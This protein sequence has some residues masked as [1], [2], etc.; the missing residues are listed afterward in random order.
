MGVKNSPMPRRQARMDRG[1]G[2]AR[3]SPLLP[4]GKPY[5]S[6]ELAR[7]AAALRGEGAAATECLNKRDCGKWHVRVPPAVRTLPVPVARRP[8]TG[9]PARVKLLV[10]TRAGNGE[11]EAASCECC[12]MHLGRYGGQVQHIVA[13]G[14]GGT[15]NPVLQTAA[16]GALLCGTPQDGCHGLAESRDPEMRAKGFWLPQGSDPRAEPMMLHSR[17]GS[18]VLVWRSADGLYLF[19]APVI[20]A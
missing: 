11:I 2:P 13:R 6:P 19:E 16:N 4:C 12:G 1:T 5:A 3:R 10:R 15:S 17:H 7:A 20:A 14:M 8:V 9:F 18:G